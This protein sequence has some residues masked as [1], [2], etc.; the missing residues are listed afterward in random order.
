MWEEWFPESN[1]E[2]YDFQKSSTLYYS[3]KTSYIFQGSTPDQHPIRLKKG[4]LLG[5]LQWAGWSDVGCILIRLL[6]FFCRSCV[7]NQCRRHPSIAYDVKYDI[8]Q[9]FSPQKI[10]RTLKELKRDHA[11]YANICNTR[12]SQI[13]PYGENRKCVVKI[14]RA[15][16]DWITPVERQAKSKPFMLIYK[17]Y[18]ASISGRDFG[19]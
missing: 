9:N 18:I 14:W 13:P 11:R 10:A 15:L 16:T 5:R 2:N 19:V 1:T 3:Q 8:A 6:S 12:I 17:V 4:R 7:D